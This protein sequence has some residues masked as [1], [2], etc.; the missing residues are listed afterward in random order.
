MNDTRT[1]SRKSNEISSYDCCSSRKLA[2]LLTHRSSARG[3]MDSNEKTHDLRV[4]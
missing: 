2:L 3:T 4:H 1:I